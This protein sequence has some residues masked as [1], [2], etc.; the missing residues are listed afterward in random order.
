MFH[1]SG[2]IIA[3][4]AVIIISLAAVTA[5]AQ[6]G[7]SPS[8]GNNDVAS[9]VATPADPLAN[10]SESDGEATPETPVEPE[11]TAT[12]VPPSDT[13]AGEEE[14]GAGSAVAP[15]PTLAPFSLNVPSVAV[16]PERQVAAP[17]QLKVPAIGV[18]TAI[19]W[20][21][22]DDEGNMDVPSE[23]RTVAWY[24]HG[25]NPGMKGNA[26]VAGHLDSQTGP[27]VF[28]RLGDLQPGDEIIVVTHDG[29]EQRFAVTGVE[30]FDANSAP[31]YNIFGASG[32]ANLNLITCEGSFDPD[33]RQYDKRL[34]VYST[35]ISD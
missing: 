33:A 1:R 29:E 5:L 34:V 32:S 11:P 2:S 21:G 35:L 30:S 31:L 3:I 12:I 4:I 20:V 18:D 7:F 10:Q 25:P 19:E 28:Y 17:L 27:A 9:T 22:L 26:V 6:P 16:E 8:G 15:I 14:S 24:E 23:Y 13:P